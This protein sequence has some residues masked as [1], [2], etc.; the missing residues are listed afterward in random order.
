MFD[1]N[2]LLKSGTMLHIKFKIVHF[3]THEVLLQQICSVN[4]S[5]TTYISRDFVQ[6]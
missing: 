1:I 4:P 5:C 6:I 3:V 2:M